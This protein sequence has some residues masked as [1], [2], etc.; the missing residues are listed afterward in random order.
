M[1]TH[2]LEHLRLSDFDYELPEA[3]IAQEPAGER[4]RSRLMA[5]DRRGGSIRHDIFSNITRFLRAGDVLVLNNTRVFP[6]RIP[7]TKAG[8]GKAE[9]FLL[10]EK[11]LNLWAALVPGGVTA[12]KRLSAGEGIEAQIEEGC[13]GGV[14]LVRFHGTPD[15]REKLASLGRTPLPPYIKREP[16]LPDIERYQTVYASQEGAVAAPTAGLHFTGK[17]LGQ[18]ADRGVETA[19]VTLHVG[20]GTFQPVR[21]DCIA[22]HKMHPERYEISAEAAG[23]INRAKEEGRRIVAVGTTSVRTIETAARD[24]GRVEPGSGSSGLFIY[25][26]FTFRVVDALITNFHLPKSTLLMLVSAFAGRD[27]ILNAYRTAVA[28]RYRFYSY[29]DAMFIA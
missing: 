29:G 8:G 4:D 25:P 26:G 3:L 16:R 9:V 20:P 28:E 23:K 11:G 24:A 6:C 22:E 17:L 5:L 10:E 2:A 7:V 21:V 15:I 13:R 27:N 12:G 1:V 19:E 18:L 14:K